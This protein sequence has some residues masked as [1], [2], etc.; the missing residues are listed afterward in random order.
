MTKIRYLR[1]TA[2][3]ICV[4]EEAQT[5]EAEMF[6]GQQRTHSNSLANE[7]DRKRR[8]RNLLSNEKE[9]DSLGQQD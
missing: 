3:T 8:L 2:E 7:R 6:G 5:K 4:R 9:E 1:K